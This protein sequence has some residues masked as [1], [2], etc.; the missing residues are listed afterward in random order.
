MVFFSQKR[1]STKVLINIS[2]EGI[3]GAVVSSAEGKRRDVILYYTGKKTGKGGMIN[4]FSELTAL[5][6]E[7][8]SEIAKESDSS[9]GK[10]KKFTKNSLVDFI[11]VI[12]SPFQYSYLSSMSS[13]NEEP[14]KISDETIKKI[15]EKEEPR[16]PEN[17]DRGFWE[18][19][20][21]EFAKKEVTEVTLNG[22]SAQIIHGKEARHIDLSV[23]NTVIPQKLLTS[24]RSRLKGEFKPSSVRFFA[25][26]DVDVSF[27][28]NA[29]KNK[30]DLYKYV[31]V[32]MSDTNVSVVNGSK[33]ESVFY[34]GKGYLNLL[35]EISKEF[36]VP[37]DVAKSYVSMFLSGAGEEGFSENVGKVVHRTLED[38]ERD[39]EGNM[40]YMPKSVYL[41]CAKRFEEMFRN[42]LIKKH[43][44]TEVMTLRDVYEQNTGYLVNDTK[45]EIAVGAYFVNRIMSNQ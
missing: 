31:R 13:E 40:N 7:V 35:E 3:D 23:F 30:D 12:D 17:S 24:L 32:N 26:S 8:I 45:F 9:R 16:K 19:E 25:R 36:N 39:Y 11:F 5:V 44:E 21:L 2:E 20:K 15:I 22:Y 43:P 38:W 42:V 27:L 41:N 28:N 4:S 33:T 6:G 29:R 14:V 10:K 1:S 34:L 37:Y 18:D